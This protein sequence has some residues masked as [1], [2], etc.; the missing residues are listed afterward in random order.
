MIE[1]MHALPDPALGLDQTS[2]LRILRI[3]RW[4]DPPFAYAAAYLVFAP[5]SLGR[6]AAVCALAVLGML[7][8]LQLYR[9]RIF[10]ANIRNVQASARRYVLALGLWIMS[11]TTL[12]LIFDG[13]TP[14]LP[15]ALLLGTW[16][17]LVRMWFS[18][19]AGAWGML[20]LRP[21][22]RMW[23]FGYRLVKAP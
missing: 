22:R 9:H 21:E 23:P 18:R 13:R 14:H 11:L 2:L 6:Q 7:L 17:T 10:G 8:R 16:L 3:K 4:I 5:D 1:R 19:H 15:T 20:Y 12:L